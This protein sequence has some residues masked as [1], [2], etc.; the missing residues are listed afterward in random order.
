MKDARVVPGL[1]L[2]R[3]LFF[4]DDRHAQR[5]MTN[6]QMIRRRS[7]DDSAADDDHID[8]LHGHL[9]PSNAAAI[10]AEHVA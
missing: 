9:T 5:W 8:S 3:L 2:T 7:S 1:V 4:L 10:L 6:R